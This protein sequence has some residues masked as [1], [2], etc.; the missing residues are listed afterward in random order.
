MTLFLRIFMVV[1]ALVFPG[2]G[3]QVI[4]M[5]KNLAENFIE[6]KEVFSEVDEVL[7]QK[8]FTKQLYYFSRIFFE[9]KFF[10]FQI[11][12]HLYSF[13]RNSEV[14]VPVAQLDRVSDYGLEG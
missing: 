12:I 10:E 4:G 2:Q 9:N 5:G 13:W 6:A 3:S 8:L 11:F 14:N 1:R 7:K